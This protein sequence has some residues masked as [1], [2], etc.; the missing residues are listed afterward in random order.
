RLL[1]FLQERTFYPVGEDRPVTVDVRVVAAT[2]ADLKQKVQRGEFREDL[3]Y[4][5]RVIDITLP[6]LRDRDGDLPIL[7]ELFLARFSKR[8]NKNITGIS[9]QALQLLGAYRWPGNV[10]EL[11]HVVERACVLCADDT[12]TTGNLPEEVR[13]GGRTVGATPGY[14]GVELEAAANRGSSPPV[15]QESE[16]AHILSIIAQTDGNKAKA[17]RLLGIDRSTLY[18]KM[19]GYGLE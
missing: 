9:D 14:S 19:K 4:R 8:L 3:Y 17:A 13:T 6:P 12:I 5:L 1:R 2:H 15:S 11:E 10:R 16:K 18:R 7:V